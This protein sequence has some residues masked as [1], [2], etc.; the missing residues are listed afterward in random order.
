MKKPF[1]NLIILT[2]TF[3]LLH[4]ALAPSFS[5]A[6]NYKSPG[7]VNSWI[8]SFVSKNSGVAKLHKIA[9]SPG[10]VAVNMIEIGLETSSVNKV[11][12]AVLV[13]ANMNGIR[14]L[15]TEGAIFMAE[16]IVKDKELF[17][18]RSWYILPLGN[19]D[20]AARYFSKTLFENTA[21]NL[22]ANNDID[23][24]SDED[25]VNDLNGDGFI[26]LMRVQHPEGNMVSVADDPR[27]MRKADPK[28]GEKGVY[29]I[30]SEGLDDDGDGKF[31]EDGFG[32]TNVNLNFPQL[33]NHF[34]AST[35]LYPGSAPE[36]RGI[37][38]F[39]FNH[40]E[41]GMVIAFGATNFCM[42]APKG[43]RSGEV[44]LSKI[45]IPERFAK[46]FNADTDKTYSMEEIVEMVQPMVP[47]GMEVTE[48]MIASFLGL[49]A[50]VN[51]LPADLEIY[52]SYN[53]KY[54]EYLE[55]K[56]VKAERFDPEKA[57]D[58]SFEL[59][60]YYH[61]GVPV[62]SMDLWSVNKAEKKTK[63]E[64]GSG[65]TLDA[66]EKMSSE[67][68]IAL[69]E[70]KIAAFL[71][72]SGAPEQFKAER[73]I[74]MMESGQFTPAQMAGMMKQMPKP[75]SDDKEADPKEKALL[76]YSDDV[77]GGKGFVNWEKYNHPDLGEVEIGGFVP[78]MATTP[79]YS[80]VDS[81]LSIQIPWLFTIAEDL[82]DLNIFETKV[83][84]LGSGV[85]Q[86]E[87]WIEN[88]ALIPF[89]IAMGSRN[90]QPAPAIVVLEGKGVEFLKGY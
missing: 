66:F 81:I 24:Q 12:P 32:G 19:P 2:L 11:K 6:K 4:I 13:V 71:K 17:S 41:I 60:A 55:E 29:K 68:V 52:T 34:D 56:G 14:P 90:S 36:A 54:K 26:T 73:V 86:L 7:E 27:L 46:I 16:S 35:G 21:N 83:T 1:K 18:N 39:S 42:T 9:V 15:T 61:L 48:S 78:Y 76:A 43:G 10:G 70:E 31:N 82:P 85:Y 67:D 44:D 49:G 64:E 65:L 63:E 59:W 47:A 58:G 53:K 87:I 50:V 25:G 33:F 72:E 89:P 3:G 22:P 62:F 75:K 5:Q 77:L 79:P 40:P 69:G 51:P 80:I 88:N 20:A 30:Y 45:K 28:D 23:D 37:L 38:E 57:K 84:D 8:T 74:Q